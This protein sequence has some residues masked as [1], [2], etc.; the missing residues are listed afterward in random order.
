LDID[1]ITF[2]RMSL[3]SFMSDSEQLSLESILRC[4]PILLVNLIVFG[5]LVYLVVQTVYVRSPY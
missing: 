2:F 5:T 3:E 4:L 1:D